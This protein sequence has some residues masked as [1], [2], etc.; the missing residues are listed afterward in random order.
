MESKEKHLLIFSAAWCN[1]CRMM[2]AMVWNDPSV[3]NKLKSFDSVNFLDIDD[4]KNR[5][6]TAT[7]RVQGVPMIYIVDEEGVPVKVGSTMDVNGTLSFL[8]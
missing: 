4:P 1:P 8:S 3:E 2:K 6:L 7:Y 5:G